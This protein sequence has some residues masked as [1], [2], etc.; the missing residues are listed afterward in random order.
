MK[1]FVQHF[2][3]Q[4]NLWKFLFWVGLGITTAGFVAGLVN[5]SWS[6]LTIFLAVFGIFITLVSAGLWSGKF[7]HLLQKRA[8]RAG[9]DALIATISLIVILGWFN[10]LVVRYAQSWD[11]TETQLFTLAPQ[12]QQLVENLTQPLKVWIF[13][14][15]PSPPDRNLLARYAKLSPNFEYE[16]VDPQIEIGLSQQYAVEQLGEV[17][18]DY[19]NK[20]QLV[21]ILREGQPLS[22]I[23]ITNGIEKILRD[24][25][26]KVYFLQGHGELPLEPVERGLSRAVTSLQ[27]RG[28]LVEPL[29]L[30]DESGIPEDATVLAIASPERP[31]F[32]GER[33]AV[34]RYLEQGGSLLLLLAP[35]SEPGLDALLEEWGIEVDDRLTIDASGTGSVI[36]YG[37]TT[38]LANR[39]GTHP[40]TL[41]FGNRFSVYPL[42]TPIMIEEK[43]NIRAIPI[44]MTHEESWA[45]GDLTSDTLEFDPEEDLPGPIN[46]GVALERAFGSEEESD[47]PEDS[48]D[49]ESREEEENPEEDETE[50]TTESNPEDSDGRATE[51]SSEEDTDATQTDSE[52]SENEEPEED[53]KQDNP[54]PV[55][56]VVFGNASFATNGWFEQQFNSDVFLNS[57]KW[58]AHEDEQLLSIRPR[59]FANRRVNLSTELAVLLAWLAIAFFPLCAFVGAGA[60]WWIKR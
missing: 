4:H 44:V 35:D 2:H 47:R 43:D 6:F 42:S 59:E 13:E 11:F 30:S 27:E 19:G 23:Q 60:I 55:R 48:N 20:T 12:T 25:S 10:F 9:T 17:H 50:K 26:P 33:E 24:R 3:F 8:T 1:N 57:V 22:E 51:E 5:G 31:L 58:L 32:L 7:R 46:I 15:A 14:P 41:E 36:G 49:F 52:E 40:I 34:E 56:M 28:Y 54:P 39:Y 21:Q 38:P 45:E 53:N 37:P 16:F 29:D 18:L